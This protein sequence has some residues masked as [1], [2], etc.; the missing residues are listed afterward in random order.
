MFDVRQLRDLN[1]RATAMLNMHF[2]GYKDLTKVDDDKPARVVNN[3]IK[4][5][6]IQQFTKANDR[7]LDLPC[8]SGNDVEKVQHLGLA[9]YV[10][11]DL[12]YN[13][14]L[15]AAAKERESVKKMGMK[16]KLYKG[17]MCNPL[18]QFDDVTPGSFDVI[19][20]QFAMHYAFEDE[21]T[22]AGFMNNISMYL[23]PGGYFIATY[24]DG[25]NILEH[26]RTSTIFGNSHY[27]ISF[28][29]RMPAESVHYGANY[30]FKLT[31]CVN[32][33][34]FLIRESVLKKLFASKNFETIQIERFES[35]CRKEE[36]DSAIGMAYR[37]L[38]DDNKE[39]VDLYKL[40]VFR[41]KS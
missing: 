33:D 31:T 14:A 2:E 6:L 5:H 19:S 16:C 21:H 41:K 18:N 32:D 15:L 22:A 17:N 26:W 1:S 12:D 23:K 25:E 34:E 28:K 39:I 8:G 4:Q 24:P 27:N 7:F 36:E 3:L 20:C 11:I 30:H 38:D 13:N 40:C 37:G 10:G 35:F 29:E 9:Q